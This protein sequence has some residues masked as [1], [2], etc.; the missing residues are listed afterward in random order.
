[1]A[2]SKRHARSDPS[3]LIKLLDDL[4][5]TGAQHPEDIINSAPELIDRMRP[6]EPRDLYQRARETQRILVATIDALERPR[7]DALRALY[8]LDPVPRGHKLLLNQT[9]RREK[10][11]VVYRVSGETMRRH[12][13]SRLLLAL[14]VELDHRLTRGVGTTHSVISAIIK[15]PHQLPPPPMEFY[16]RARER[17]GTRTPRSQKVTEHPRSQE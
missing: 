4:L 2:K 11:G 10:T 16:R 8:S 17:R 7:S 13:E 9:E 12:M 1:M 6:G 5:A 3:G 14:A 15:L